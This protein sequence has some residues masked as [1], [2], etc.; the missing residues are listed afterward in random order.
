MEAE[1]AALAGLI[2]AGMVGLPF[3]NAFMERARMKKA[4]QDQL[5]ARIN[6]CLEKIHDNEVK[7][8]KL[9]GIN[10]GRLQGR[11]EVREE[12]NI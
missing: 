6:Q 10:E 2:L 9:E 4:E 5:H 3:Y 1:A 7:T 8:A 11:Q 12:L